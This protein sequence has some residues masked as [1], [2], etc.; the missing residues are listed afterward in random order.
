MSVSRL[1]NIG[2]IG[3][4]NL[5]EEMTQDE[6]IITVQV[7]PDLRGKIVKCRLV[8]SPEITVLTQRR[9]AANIAI[10]P[11][12]RRITLQQHI[13]SHNLKHI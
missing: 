10:R 3:K 13:N 9:A 1:G 11:I 7:N 6:A 2:S 8:T 4:V 12:E 5:N